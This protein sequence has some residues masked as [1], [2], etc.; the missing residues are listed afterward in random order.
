MMPDNSTLIDAFAGAIF[1]RTV[2]AP[3]DRI[4]L[5]IQLSG[6]IRV[7]HQQV[8]DLSPK[9]V[10]KY[11]KISSFVYT[12]TMER[13]YPNCTTNNNRRRGYCSQLCLSKQV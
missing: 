5:L 6:S 9:V 4:K 12:I 10:Q 8:H 1:A 11:L 3:I 13:Q 2:V 7:N